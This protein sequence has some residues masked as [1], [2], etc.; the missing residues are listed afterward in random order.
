MQN[1]R[2]I[3]EDIWWLGASDRRIELFENVYPVP[4]GI[5]YNNYLIMDEKTCLMDGVDDSVTGQFLENLE[6]VLNG[7]KL[8]YMV[9]Q[10]MEP[11]HC[12]AIPQL[13]AKYPELKI[14]TSA[15]A[16]K[17]INQFYRFDPTDRTIIVKEGSSLKLGKHELSFVCAPMVHWPEVLMSFDTATGTL[18]SADA[19]GAFG[20]IDGNLFADEVDWERDWADESRRYYVNIVGKYGVQVNAVLKKAAGLDIKMICP[21]HAHV[22]RKDFDKLLSRYSK[23]ASYEPEV[24]S[25][26]VFY[27]S[28]YGNTA[29]AADILASKLAEKG[30]RNIKVFDSSKTD[31]SE[32]VSRAFQYSTLV[33]ASA[34][35]NAEVFD[36]MHY[37]L[38]DLKNHN[39]ANRTVGL[40]EN[41][42]WAPMAA[43]LMQR[44]LET[45]KNMNVI[46]PIVRIKSGVSDENLAQL[47]ELA[48]K[49]AESLK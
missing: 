33:F 28:I 19:F 31:I 47:E 32:M 34:T 22:W 14:V 35:Y 39:L 36:R 16:L 1:A 21:L 42:T 44:Q 2:K 49:L 8:D 15:Q 12:S 18:F 26:A 13:V 25:V 17:M 23:W 20:A 43:G 46:E 38:I 27:G 45:M 6:H 41:G 30:V 40:I 10:H 9:V 48:E 3:S 37:L 11:D 7:R 5:S 24:R 4:N 29:N